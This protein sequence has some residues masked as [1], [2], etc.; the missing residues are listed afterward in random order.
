MISSS[1]ENTCWNLFSTLT[2][3]NMK[4][5]LLTRGEFLKNYQICIMSQVETHT[6]KYLLDRIV[7]LLMSFRLFP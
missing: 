2:T 4:F 1:L 6:S 3:K 5:T 7:L